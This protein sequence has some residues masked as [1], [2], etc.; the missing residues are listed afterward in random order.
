VTRT[1]HAN[2]SISDLLVARLIEVGETWHLR[3]KERTLE[4]RITPD[5]QLVANR[6]VFVTPSAAASS[7]TGTAKNGWFVW[8]RWNGKSWE[9]ISA[10]RQR[11]E[12]RRAASPGGGMRK[13]PAK[14][15]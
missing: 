11:L 4:G 12:E 10:A 6:K 13:E 3:T 5:G 1:H 15:R 7:L 8:W 9:R 2:I 14:R